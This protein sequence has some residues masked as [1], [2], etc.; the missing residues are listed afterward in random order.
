MVLEL[1]LIEPNS[2]DADFISQTLRNVNSNI[3]VECVRDGRAALDY[4]FGTGDYAHRNSLHQPDLI[5]LNL[6][7]E[8]VMGFSGLDVLRVAK[9]YVRTRVIPIVILSESGNQGA[10]RESYQFSA[11]SYVEKS[12]D[13][14]R[15]RTELELMGRYWLTINKSASHDT[16][17]AESDNNAK[18]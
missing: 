11:N 14:N 16:A 5:L 1:L 10:M 17:P 15:F 13:R 12:T 9:S 6:N 2:I 4:L 3:H 18:A 8:P 7:L